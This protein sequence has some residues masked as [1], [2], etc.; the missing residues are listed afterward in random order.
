MSRQGTRY[1]KY[2]RGYNTV[3]KTQHHEWGWGRGAM[4]RRL[5]VGWERRAWG[6][7]ESCKS[8]KLGLLAV[9]RPGAHRNVRWWQPRLAL[10]TPNKLH[11]ESFF[12]ECRKQWWYRLHPSF[13][14]SS[15][16]YLSLFRNLFWSFLVISLN[17]LHVRTKWFQRG[18]SHEQVV[19]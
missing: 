3:L 5:W 9:K 16:F 10:P 7:Q 12:S 11:I 4:G 17:W 15:S 2:T 14:P 13:P 6:V 8:W 1:T 19:L 18:C